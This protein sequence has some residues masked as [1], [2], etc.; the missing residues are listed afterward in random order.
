VPGMLFV[1]CSVGKVEHLLVS[2]AGAH[3]VAQRSLDAA[4]QADLYKIASQ[5]EGILELLTFLSR[6]GC[7]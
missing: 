7:I 1:E 6:Y 5:S 4:E 3:R 2:R